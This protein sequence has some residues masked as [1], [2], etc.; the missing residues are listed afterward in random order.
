MNDIIAKLYGAG[1][2]RPA[3]PRQSQTPNWSAGASGD[4]VGGI[5]NTAA[6]GEDIKWGKPD[7][8][9]ANAGQIV[10]TPAGK[11]KVVETADGFALEPTEGALR[12]VSPTLT[13]FT[14]GE[15]H[16]GI[17]PQTGEVWYQKAK[18]IPSQF[19]QAS[20]EFNTSNAGAFD[21]SNSVAFDTSNA[22]AFNTSNAGAFDTS[23]A[24]AFVMGDET[25]PEV[26]YTMGTEGVLLD[27]SPA[28][29]RP[30]NGVSGTPVNNFTPAAIRGFNV[31]SNAVPE[32]IQQKKPS[33][34]DYVKMLNEM[35]INSLFK[36][37]I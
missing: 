21:T 16:L 9:D 13:N 25:P 32:L 23:N 35:L 19:S 1:G 15:H 20:Q 8:A 12:G 6:M 33:N 18:D 29:A 17:N 37:M 11:Y 36:D 24:G 4:T 30:V 27:G 2:G 22:V 3:R 5:G 10:D 28:P 31:F 26:G 34:A 14:A 7:R